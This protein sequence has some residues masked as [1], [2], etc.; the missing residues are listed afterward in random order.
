MCCQLDPQTKLDCDSKNPQSSV[1]TLEAVT[2][3]SDN[4]SPEE[5]EIMNLLS[6]H[7]TFPGQAQQRRMRAARSPQDLPS[8]VAP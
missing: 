7:L 3:S 8:T 6:F 5:D 2:L 4:L 1:S